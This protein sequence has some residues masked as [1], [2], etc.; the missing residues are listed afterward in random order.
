MWV[1]NIIIVGDIATMKPAPFRYERPSS[2]EEVLDALAGHDDPTILAGGQSLVPTM[3]NRLA[4]PETVIDINR[5]D[6]LEYIREEDGELSIGALVR[7]AEAE[8]SDVVAEGCPLVVEALEHLGHQTVRNRGTIGGNLTHGDPT[9]ELPAVA[10]ACDATLVVQSSDGERTVD[11]EEFFQGY[12][13]TDVGPNE[14]L[15]EIRFPTW[16]DGR[17][18]AFEEIA[19]REGDYALTGVAATL[20]VEDGSCTRARLA[21]N[22]VADRPVRV[23]EAE[24]VVVGGSTDTFARASAVA[25]E[26]LDPPGDVHGSSAYRENLIESLTRRALEQ[27]ANRAEAKR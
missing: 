18:W 8:R 12:M 9:S 19:P 3:N 14:L 11:A 13:M 25:R 4:T 24:D 5:V 10:L 2:V 15:T 20:D 23:P 22:A 27:A 1:I 6:G 17:G 16:S 21:Y 26:Q 7:Q